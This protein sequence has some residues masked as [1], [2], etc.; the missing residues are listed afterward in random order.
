MA[1]NNKN[2]CGSGVLMIVLAALLAILVFNMGSSPE[3]YAP[4]NEKKQ[5]GFRNNI[6]TTLGKRTSGYIMPPCSSCSG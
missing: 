6:V 3:E 4:I 5:K 1:N 2:T